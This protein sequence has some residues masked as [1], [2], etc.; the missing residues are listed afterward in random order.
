[1]K[2]DKKPMAEMILDHTLE[3]IYLLTGEDY[4]VVKK[5][6]D[7]IT[8]SSSPCVPEGFCRTQ[9]PD[10]DHPT[11]SLIHERS[12]D[13]KLMSEKILE[14]TNKIIHLL[15]GEV[16]IKCDDV[17][18]YFSMEEWEYLEG[19]RGSYKDVMENNQSLSSLARSRTTTPRSTC[20]GDSVT[21]PVAANQRMHTH[22]N[23][24]QTE[25]FI[26]PAHP[27]AGLQLPEAP[28]AEIASHGP[29]QPISACTPTGMQPQVFNTRKRLT[30][31]PC[32]VEMAETT[33]K[34]KRFTLK[35]KIAALDRIRSGVQ[36]TQVA[37][38]LGVN[39]STV[40]G[41]KK[42]EHKL[43]DAAKSM[44]TDN[45][46]KRNRLRKPRY[47]P[48]D[49]AVFQW[50]VKERSEGAPLSGPLL[51][52]QAKKVYNQLYGKE[53]IPFTA[54]SGWLNRFR[55]RHGISKSARSGEIRPADDEAAC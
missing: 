41:W 47:N 23:A 52:T 25:S 8:D 43:R 32:K 27:A 54:S 22:R 17:A 34:R 13:K 2:K 30:E 1:M 20:S 19:H 24:A 15:T 53:S 33:N 12:N 37:R 40:R 38:D 14:L 39:E 31:D 4:I 21:W 11:N 9:R 49:K 18:V 7:R 46:L 36:Q 29:L 3:I 16:P 10:M 6:G 50:F 35:E 5:H 42:E 55:K 51:Q 44:E 48:L 45:G 26:S 28:A